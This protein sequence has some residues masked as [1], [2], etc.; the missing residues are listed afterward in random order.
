MRLE[1]VTATADS[2]PHPF[3]RDDAHGFNVTK[4]KLSFSFV[5]ILVLSFR[6]RP[7]KAGRFVLAF[8]CPPKPS[9]KDRR[10]DPN[11]HVENFKIIN[12]MTN[13]EYR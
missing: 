2:A 6:A 3:P 12:A 8:L 13:E 7:N 11:Y 4:H 10:A 5:I 9:A 1:T